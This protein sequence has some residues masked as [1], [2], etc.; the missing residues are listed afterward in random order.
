M[1]TTNALELNDV[2]KIYKGGF[3]AVDNINLEVKQGD[4]FALL[5]PNGAGK[6]TTL[7]MISSLVNKTSGQIKIFGH[8]LDNDLV[9]AKKYLGMMPQE[10]NLNIFETPLQILLTQAGYFGIT[11]NAVK[12]YAEKLLNDMALWDKRDEHV[13]FLSGGMKRRL[14]VARA[15]IHQPKLLILDE[16]TAGVDV[17]L[18]ES[19]WESMQALNKEGLTI[20]LTTHYLEEAENMCNRIALINHGKVSVNS[21]MKSLLREVSLEAYNIDAESELKNETYQFDFGTGVR[22][23][24]HSLEV[25]INKGNT[26]TTVF[27]QLSD[28]GINVLNISAKKSRLES[29]F[30]QTAKNNPKGN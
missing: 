18:R 9:R 23:N 2:T 29:L 10:V 30:L 17:E 25:V 4:F 14:M 7:G 6:S 22:T 20:I 12:D 3:K 11:R 13:R 5:G 28:Q 19:M 27:E 15:L 24:T 26:L 16:P 21:D 8:D 1:T